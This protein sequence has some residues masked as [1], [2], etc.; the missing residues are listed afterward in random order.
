MRIAKPARLTLFSTASVVVCL[1]LLSTTSAIGQ[2]PAYKVTAIK[3]MLYFEQTGTF[4][5]DVLASPD[6]A[7]WNTIIGEGDA[8]SPSSSTLV[9]VEVTG[10]AGS[11]E[12]TR[13]VELTATYKP[14]G[15]NTRELTVKRATE[16]NIL[17]EKGKFYA[18]FWL[19]ETG[20]HPVT[21]LARIVGQAQPAMMRKTINFKCGE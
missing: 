10:K 9:L 18:P 4:S 2:P 16:V 14:N 20:C 11:Y 7:F 6:F 13:K 3:A 12:P 8:G 21:L 5:K 15:R 1:C 19:S 17:S